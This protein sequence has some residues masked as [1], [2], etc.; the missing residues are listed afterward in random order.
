MHS[1]WAWM[2]A[3]LVAAVGL[4]VA[5]RFVFRSGSTAESRPRRVAHGLV[6]TLV[7]TAVTLVAI[8]LAFKFFF[9]QSDG[10][11]FTLAAKNWRERHWRPLNAQGF[12]DRE[13][14]PAELRG[15]RRIAVVGDSIVAGAGIERVADRFSDRLGSKLGDGYAV[16]TSGGSDGRPW[17]S[18]R[19]SARF[20]IDHTW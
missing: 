20:P 17:K 12:R 19:R 14:R 2:F 10:M 6:N 11:S 9:A 1:Y 4:A 3:I 15:R 7:A 13:W 5:A 8:E 18:S 16:L